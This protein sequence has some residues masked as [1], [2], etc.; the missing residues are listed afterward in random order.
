[1]SMSGRPTR[2]Q[3]ALV[4][5]VVVGGPDTLIEAV[6]RCAGDVSRGA[7]VVRTQVPSAATHIARERPF[8]IV[9]SEELYAFDAE[10]FDA[11]A[12]DVR[13]TVLALPTV[14][15]AMD[16]LCQRLMPLLR[17]AFREHFRK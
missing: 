11:L 15:V 7:R 3:I 14:D 13:A 1:M 12:R 4:S 10:E 2:E 16:A 5:I 9:L 17:D 8:A 6:R